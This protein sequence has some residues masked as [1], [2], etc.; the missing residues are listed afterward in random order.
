MNSDTKSLANVVDL[1]ANS[2]T[3]ANGTLV[4]ICHRYKIQTLS[5]FGSILGGRFNTD[6]DVD[7]L[8]EFEPDARI[9]YLGMAQIEAELT[10][11]MGRR[12]DL[13]TP[14]ELSRYFRSDVLASAKVLYAG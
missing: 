14:S 9:G 12:V 8:V 13:R 11:L 7:I 3:I 1:M 2:P 5:L 4:D 6:S 10:E